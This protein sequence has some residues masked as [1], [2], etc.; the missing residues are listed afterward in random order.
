MTA[1]QLM[2]DVADALQRIFLS[3]ISTDII[4]TSALATIEMR[5]HADI[6]VIT[7]KSA[8]ARYPLDHSLRLKY[9]EIAINSTQAKIRKGGAHLLV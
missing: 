6:R 8:A 2:R 9:A 1:I 4:N 3:S 5:M 7:L